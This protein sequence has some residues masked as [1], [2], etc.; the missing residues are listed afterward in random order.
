MR[1][2]L[3]RVTPAGL[4]L[5][6]LVDFVYLAKNGG[7]G[8]PDEEKKPDDP[9]E[10][11]DFNRFVTRKRKQPDDMPKQPPAQSKPA[12]APKQP[13]EKPKTDDPVIPADLPKATSRPESINDFR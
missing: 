2:W 7:D 4:K 3:P 13:A 11:F 6:P 10:N 12:D 9:F 8:P 5:N 1:Y